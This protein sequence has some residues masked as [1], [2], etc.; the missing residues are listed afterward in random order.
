MAMNVRCYRCG[1]SFSLGREAI[2]AALAEA[3]ASR[4][5]YHAEYCPRCRQVN[6]ISIDQLKRA[7][8][9]P[10]AAGEAE[11]PAPPGSESAEDTPKG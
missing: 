6:K 2:V 9:A 11:A 10:A 8:P 5:K 3:Q 4:A 1:W 7:A